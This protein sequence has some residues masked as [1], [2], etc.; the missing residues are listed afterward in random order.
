MPV[1][2]SAAKSI[3]LAALERPD[4][5]AYLDSACAGDADIRARVDELLKA[6]EA[7]S[8]PDFAAGADDTRTVAHTP[9]DPTRTEGGVQSGDAP[10]LS[11]LAPPRES[12]HLGRLDHFEILS[13]VG[14]GGM[15]VVLKA[16]DEIVLYSCTAPSP[17]PSTFAFP[18]GE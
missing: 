13:V 12:G 10:D 14:Q 16:H 15:G 4:H 11:F 6:H 7:G 2:A 17:M 8:F 5:A 1:D 18:A 9:G 3:F